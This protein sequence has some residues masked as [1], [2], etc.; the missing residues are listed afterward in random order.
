M[1]KTKVPQP[2]LRTPDD[3]LN[4]VERY[5]LASQGVRGHL[6]EEFRD[7]Q[8]ENVTDETEQL[9]KSHGL[10]LEYNRAKTGREKDWMFMVRISVPGGGAFTAEQWRII[11][12]AATRHANANPYGNVSIRLTTRQNIQL[13]WVKKP[14]VIEL[15]QEI[16]RTGFYTMNGCGD[17]TRNVMACPLGRFSDLYD[18]NAK[19]HQYGAYFRLPRDPHIQVFA[20]DP[21]YV[22]EPG[23][24]YDYGP[25][26]LNRKFK[27]AFSQVHRD[28]E[29]GDIQHDNCVEL[30]TNDMGIVPIVNPRT[31]K[32]DAYQVYIGGGQGEKNGKPTFATLSVPFG[33]FTEDNLM[34][35]LHEIVKV[36]EEWGDRKNR[37][38]A[39][40]KYV[41]HAQGVD[42]YRNEV[43]AKGAEFEPPNPETDPGPRM[44]HHGWHTLPADGPGAGRLA[45][46]AYVEC[47]RLVDS[48][49]GDDPEHR[50]G[51]V[52]GNG[53]LKSMVRAVMDEF[54]GLQLMITPN[55]DLLF[56]HIEPDAKDAFEARLREF[57]FGTRGGRPYST[58]RVLSGACVGLPTCRLSYTDSEQF[59]PELIDEL[60]A[61]GYGEIHEAVGITGCE[62]QCFRPATKSIGWVGQG[63]NLYGLKLGGSEDA[64]HQGEWL[65]HDGTWYLRQVPREKVADVT[66]TLFDHYLANR[67]SQAE[68]LGAF[69]R[70]LGSAAVV[71]LLK[72]NPDTAGV[73]EKTFPAPYIPE[74]DAQAVGVG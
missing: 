68:D 27:I 18:G 6:A 65:V 3:E 35:G 22:P 31:G 63:P 8:Q 54:D 59:E 16:A 42:W 66:A 7:H 2:L 24:K 19:A 39:R 13:H 32:V 72:S 45:Y 23:E 41:V 69:Y 62:R 17:N 71:E 20:I 50:S 58:L 11:D 10:Y 55:Q 53:R 28:P 52:T 25:R 40:L 26:L 9:A 64:R 14:H 46:G 29:T 5:K 51:N 38:W 47:G 30:R 15:I 70:R 67:E 44:L 21:N 34:K 57:G 33:I 49:E 12:E 1:P 61:R 4:K 43:R 60:E 37:H 74:A 36:H 48:A 56:T 73:T